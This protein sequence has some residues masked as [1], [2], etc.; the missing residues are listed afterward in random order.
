MGL[1]QTRPVEGI[2]EVLAKALQPKN[3]SLSPFPIELPLTGST[4][5]SVAKGGGLEH[6]RPVEGMAEVLAETLQLKTTL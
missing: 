3:N 6:A 4:G 5:P 1:V 2:V